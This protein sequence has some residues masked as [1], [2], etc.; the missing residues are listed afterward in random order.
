MRT[1]VLGLFKYVDRLLSASE[2]LKGEGFSVTIISPVPLVHEIEHI[3]GEKKS[4]LRYFTLFGGVLGFLFGTVLALGTS[5][6]YVMPRGGRPIFAATPTLIISYES[7]ILF[8]VIMTLLGF[9]AIAGL[10]YFEGMPHFKGEAQC[11]EAE[12]DSFGLIIEDAGG[13]KWRYI[14][15]VLKECGASEVRKLED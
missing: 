3:E 11:P 15:G 1:T 13:D 9:F 12:I 14:E 6:L 7:T 10:P 5:A 2:K 8:G 4:L